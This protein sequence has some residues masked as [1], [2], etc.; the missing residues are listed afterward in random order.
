MGSRARRVLVLFTRY[1]EPGAVKTRLIP[2]LGPSGAAR[3]HREMT[4]R[5][6]AR[7]ASGTQGA[8]DGVARAADEDSDRWP[9][10]LEVRFEGGD[11]ERMRTWLPSVPRCCAQGPGDLGERLQRAFV[12]G[13]SGGAAAVVAIGTDCP[14]LSA[15]DVADAFRALESRDAVLG[16][17]ADGGYW[18]VGIGRS[19]EGSSASLF[20]GIP[21]GGPAVFSASL[22]AATRAGL[23][24]ATLRTLA[25][26]DRPED[27]A[28]WERALRSTAAG[29]AISVVIP[30]L[31]EAGRIGALVTALLDSPGVEVIVADGG[32][33]DGTPEDAARSGARVVLAPQG[34]GTQMNAGA[35]VATGEILL[36][37]HADTRPPDGWARAAREA[38]RESGVAGGAFS[39]GTDSRHRSLRVIEAAANWRGRALGIV[40]GDQG[41]FTRK[42][43]FEAAGGFPVQTLMED[44]EAVRRLRRRGKVVLLPQRVITSARRWEAQGVWR[45]T[46]RNGG[47]TVAYVCG[48][49]A[50]RLARWYRRAPV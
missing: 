30:A 5:T 11:L 34:R 29:Q 20:R 37:L 21:W 35:A 40:F 12:E 3:L 13:F 39:L 25:D 46:L 31:N 19:A 45:T 23:S 50:E 41:L 17:A 36:F 4:E 8:A 1:P 32:S 14:D 42:E 33:G 38:L 48:V 44:Y 49:S 10:D 2:A 9:W 18:I 24:V 47:I 28:A 7:V 22:E 16:P 15:G 27:L 26:V 43:T 6:L